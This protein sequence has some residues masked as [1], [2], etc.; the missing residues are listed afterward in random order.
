MV[1]RRIRASNGSLLRHYGYKTVRFKKHDETVQVTFTVLDVVRPI[2][3]TSDMIA[4]SGI[5]S[6][7]SGNGSY[8]EKYSHR[9][10]KHLRLGLIARLGLFFLQL[11]M[12]ASQMVSN[13]TQGIVTGS[14]NMQTS[15][16]PLSSS[17]SSK[18]DIVP[19]VKGPDE[20]TEV[21]RAFHLATNYDKYAPWCSHCIA[22]RGREDPHRKRQIDQT[23]TVEIQCDYFFLSVVKGGTQIKVLNAVD[24]VYKRRRAIPVE[25][26]GRSDAYAV[27]ALKQFVRSLGH[28]T[29]IWRGDPEH[30]LMDVL[31]SVCDG[32]S[33]WTTQKTPKGSKSSLG[34]AER[35][36]QEL[37]GFIRALKSDLETRFGTHLLLTHP[38]FAWAVRHSAWLLD[39]FVQAPSSKHSPF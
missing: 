26:K 38:I 22:G 10:R 32:E 27:R 29:I 21:V 9:Q 2:L 31:N 25:F 6:H 12:I 30:S 37:E 4:K 19:M 1:Q 16:D 17:S 28:L 35:S 5:V 11:Q 14:L 39:R 13:V 36:H 24:S 33:G 18:L 34:S 20:P 8:M 7:F 3:S 23:A 15:D